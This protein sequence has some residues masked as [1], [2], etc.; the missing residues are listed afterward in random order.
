VSPK[1]YKDVTNELNGSRTNRVFEFFKVTPPPESEGFTREKLLR[2]PLL[3]WIL[4][5]QQHL[6]MLGADRKR[7][8]PRKLHPLP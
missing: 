4:L 8:P 3:A 7:K 5:K 2:S 1:E 6:R